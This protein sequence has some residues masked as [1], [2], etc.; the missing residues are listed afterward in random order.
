MEIKAAVARQDAAIVESPARSWLRR[1]EQV[2]D[3]E[4][5]NTWQRVEYDSCCWG[6]ARRKE[7]ALESNV[8]ALCMLAAKCQHTHAA[9]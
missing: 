2:R 4:S 1:F 7:Q 6:G 8:P 3:L 5:G 9:D